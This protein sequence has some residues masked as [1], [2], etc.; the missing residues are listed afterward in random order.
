MDG[1]P[2]LWLLLV[3]TGLFLD[4]EYSKTI[5]GRSHNESVILS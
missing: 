5:F 1:G 4:N 3:C 2:V